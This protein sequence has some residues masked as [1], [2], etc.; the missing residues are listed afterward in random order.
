MLRNVIHYFHG[1]PDTSIE[2]LSE[3]VL[4]QISAES[5]DVKAAFI[6]T[7]ESQLWANIVR[8]YFEHGDKVYQFVFDCNKNDM[9]NIFCLQPINNNFSFLRIHTA[10][11]QSAFWEKLSLEDL[12][13]DFDNESVM[14]RKLMISLTKWNIENKYR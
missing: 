13:N 10:F 5:F 3:D 12:Q 14:L 6:G 8:G 4:K 2:P 11:G 9:T 1:S 7:P